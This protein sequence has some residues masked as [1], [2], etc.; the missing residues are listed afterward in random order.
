MPFAKLKVIM[1]IYANIE[2]PTTL[3]IRLSKAPQKTIQSCVRSQPD[4]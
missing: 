3:D 2:Y 4:M 1:S